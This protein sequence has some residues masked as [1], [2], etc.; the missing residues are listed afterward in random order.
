[1]E[2]EIPIPTSRRS[3]KHMTENFESFLVSNLKRRA[4]EVSERHMTDEELELM[5]QGPNRDVAMRMR[6][7]LTW[8]R[9]D[10]GNRAAKARC[11]VLGYQDPHYEHRQT[12]APTM[13]RTTRH[14]LLSL[15]AALKMR[16]AKGDVS[17]AFLQGRSYQHDAYVIPTDEIC[18]AM[19]LPHGSITKLKN[20]CYGLVDAPLEWFLTVS[21][22]LQSL[23]FE[24]C[25]CDPC[26]F[27]YVDKDKG[28]IGLIRGH[29]DDFLFCGPASCPIWSNLCQQIQSKFKW[30]IWGYDNF[31][32]CGARVEKTASGGFEL[33]QSMYIDDIREI[34]IPSERRREPK[35]ATTCRTRENKD[36]SSIRCSQLVC[37]AVLPSFVCSSWFVFVTGK[38]Q[39]CSN[40]D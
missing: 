39:H 25:V 34:S 37:S 14:I 23:G 2:V 9:D 5:K 12:M 18:D 3:V 17:G 27:K 15:A 40:Y 30:G 26:C 29:V 32:Q 28:L 38:R 11:V 10:S 24:R 21:E 8:K 33:S 4:V 36:P 19:S 13:S 31:T 1:M 7:V 35:S 20:V 22:F 16:V 6:W